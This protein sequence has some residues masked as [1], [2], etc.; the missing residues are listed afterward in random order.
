MSGTAAA[1]DVSRANSDSGSEMKK[2]KSYW[3]RLEIFK[4]QD[5]LRPTPQLFAMARRPLIFLTFP[6]IAYAGFSYACF[7][8]W[9]SVLNGTE[10]LILSGKPYNFS[11]LVI[12]LP[13]IAPVI[14]V[15][16][17]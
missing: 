10:S 16:L 2:K 9:L 4:K 7:Q 3:A 11:T 15:C 8:F 13:Y 14:G 5:L 12:G 6:V 17:G 1:V